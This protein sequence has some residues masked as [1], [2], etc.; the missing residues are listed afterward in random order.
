MRG[1][2]ETE[3]LAP[4]QGGKGLKRSGADLER[5]FWIALGLYAGLAAVSWW[6]VGPGTVVVSGKPVELRLVPL[7][8]M[9]GMALK[10]VLARQ[11]NRIRH[12]G[13]K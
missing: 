2:Q 9:G 12:G 8:V 11:A 4:Q 7:I 6:M 10:T 3:G 1:R 13:D 5:K